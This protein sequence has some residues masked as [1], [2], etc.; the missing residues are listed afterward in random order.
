MKQKYCLIYFLNFTHINKRLK[1][2]LYTVTFRLQLS[3]FPHLFKICN[4]LR[5]V[6]LKI[7]DFHFFSLQTTKTKSS[8]VT[9]G[10]LMCHVLPIVFLTHDHNLSFHILLSMHCYCALPHKQC[11]SMLL[12]SGWV[13]CTKS[14]AGFCL[15][16][17]TVTQLKV[18][19]F[20]KQR[21]CS[22]NHTLC[23]NMLNVFPSSEKIC[24]AILLF[25]EFFE[26]CSIFKHY[27]IALLVVD[28]SM[29]DL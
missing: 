15:K 1:R 21:I 13:E 2:D 23:T 25:F 27:S 14:S 7:N 24:K 9:C 17:R 6:F 5:K 8:F 22:P 29:G 20:C 18:A 10:H 28:D 19:L 16:G 4:F 3:F 26:S 12:L 11:G